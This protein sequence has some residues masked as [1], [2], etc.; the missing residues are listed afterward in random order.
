MMLR[1][2]AFLVAIF[3]TY[4]AYYWWD[5]R[6]LMAFC[7]DVRVGMPVAELERIAGRHGVDRR[8]LNGNGVFQE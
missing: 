2:S 3:L 6:Q 1:F 7:D 8:W 5:M 4:L